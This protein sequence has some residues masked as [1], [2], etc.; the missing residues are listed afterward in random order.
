MMADFPSKVTTE[1]GSP[2][3]QSTQQGG[4]SLRGL[5]ANVTNNMDMSF[6]RS[7]PSV[8]MMAQIF[9]GLLHWALIASSPYMFAPANGWVLFVAVTFWLLTS[10]LFLSIVFGLQRRLSAVPWPITVMVYH[11]VATILYLTAFLANAASVQ[12]FYH[13]YFFGHMAA[14]AF[15]SAVVTAAYG[16]SAFFSY[17]DWKGDGGNAATSTVPT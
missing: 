15:F 17:L 3:S 6:I 10:I 2:S 1:T 14:A 13:T 8:L 9:L 12:P 4:N 7:I 11:G 16:V 5:A